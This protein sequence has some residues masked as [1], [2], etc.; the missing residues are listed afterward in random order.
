MIVTNFA[1]HLRRS[2]GHAGAPVEVDAVAGVE[3]ELLIGPGDHD[4]ALDDEVELLAGVRDE[5][6]RLV[7][8]VEHHEQRLHDLAGVAPG[9]SS[10][11]YPRIAVD[12]ARPSPQRTTWYVSSLAAVP[13]EDLGELHAEVMAM[14]RWPRWARRRRSPPSART[15]SSG[16]SSSAAMSSRETSHASRRPLMR[17]PISASSATMVAPYAS[18][19]SCRA[20]LFMSSIAVFLA[21]THFSMAFQ[22]VS[23]SQKR[24]S[25]NSLPAR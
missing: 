15:S 16:T 18:I 3:L 6:R 9:E 14:C 4:G 2:A 21:G 11:W 19:P 20:R 8:G 5:L 12:L 23:S 7:G 25:A 13:R 17:R 24:V 22:R 1:G 10:K